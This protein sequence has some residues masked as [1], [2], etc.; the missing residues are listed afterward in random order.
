MW[1]TIGVVAAGFL[2]IAAMIAVKEK[3]ITTKTVKK[4]PLPV[5]MNDV[6]KGN[7]QVTKESLNTKKQGSKLQNTSQ[8]SR[9]GRF[10]V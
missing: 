2:F 4:S 9:R 10:L 3:D 6:K 1:T 8:K 7:N 5:T